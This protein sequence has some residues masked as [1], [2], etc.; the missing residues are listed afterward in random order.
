MERRLRGQEE[1][2]NQQW[3]LRMAREEAHLHAGATNGPIHHTMPTSDFSK[4]VPNFGR[5]GKREDN[6]LGRS[7]FLIWKAQACIWWDYCRIPLS[8]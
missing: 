2:I 1:E 6:K 5:S 8:Q 3:Q 7:D 4:K